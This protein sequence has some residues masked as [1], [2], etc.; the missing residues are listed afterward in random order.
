MDVVALVG[1]SGTG[2]SHRASM[3]AYEHEADLIIDDGLLI[4]DG[5]IIAGR[6]AKRED[7]MIRAVKRAVFSDPQDA[8]EIKAKIRELKPKK[9]LVLG[10]S[11]T[12][13]HRIV[14]ALDLPRPSEYL[15]INDV[16]S[17]DDIQKALR[18]RRLYGKHV[19]PAPT[20]EVKRSFSGYLIDPLRI[21]FL[22]RDRSERRD[23][24]LFVEKSIVRPTFSCFGKFYIADSVISSISARAS[25]QVNGIT[26]VGRVRV[27]TTPEGVH[28]SLDVNV[29]YGGC[30]LEPMREV[31]TRVKDTV[32]FMTALNVLAVNVIATKLSVTGTGSREGRGE[33]EEG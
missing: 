2:K 3:V 32:E 19:I 17:R 23:D 21:R 1:A 25:R 7:T 16:A 29:R 6:S 9:V 33:K 26:K 18:I 8:A 12:M 4:R 22:R 28:I 5:K 14:D 13:V 24:G 31:Q 27:E 20:F 11:K 10:T 15:T 30:L